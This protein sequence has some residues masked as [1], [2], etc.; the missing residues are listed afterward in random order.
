MFPKDERMKEYVLSVLQGKKVEYQFSEEETFVVTL[1][2]EKEIIFT[3]ICDLLTFFYKTK[4]LLERLDGQG[5]CFDAYLG[6]VL[7][8]DRESDDRK[9]KTILDEQQGKVYN[10]SGFFSFSMREIVASWQNLA[11]LAEKLYLQCHDEK[12]LCAL[13]VFMLGIGEMPENNVTVDRAGR[14]F[15]NGA[16]NEVI[17]APYYLE[18]DRNF[19]LTMLSYRPSDVVVNDQNAIS[20][21]VLRVIRSLGE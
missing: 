7:A 19:V 13:T 18:Y 14:I 9:I 8:S 2:A 15:L 5:I 17:V 10:L 20:T 21:A 16:E 4:I 11:L 1:K 6:S 3:L 12:D